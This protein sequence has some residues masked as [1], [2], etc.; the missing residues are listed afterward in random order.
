MDAS[1]DRRPGVDLVGL[2]ARRD[3]LHRRRRRGLGR[4]HPDGRVGAAGRCLGRR[5]GRPAQRVAV[6]LSATCRRVGRRGPSGSPSA[7]TRRS[8]RSGRP[9]PGVA[10]H[11]P[12][13]TRPTRTATTGGPSPTTRSTRRAGASRRPTTTD[14]AADAPLFDGLADDVDPATRHTFNFTVTPAG[15]RGPTIVSPETPVIGEQGDQAADD[16]RPGGSRSSSATAGPGRTRS[17]RMVPIHGN[18]PG[19]LNES[20]LQQASTTYPDDIKAA[21]RSDAGEG[22][23]GPEA[24]QARGEDPVDGGLRQPLS[25]SPTPPSRSSSRATSTTP[26]TSAT[27]TARRSAWSSASRPSRR[28]SASTTR[29]R[30]R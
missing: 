26:S 11:D 30:W 27:S 18:D 6:H 21:L 1:P 17:R 20:A 13:A 8:A 2:P 24:L 23:L 22:M 28:G 19:E 16:R 25:T 15:Y 10:H 5:P 12:R 14:R 3:D 7:R 29:R 9:T 4:A